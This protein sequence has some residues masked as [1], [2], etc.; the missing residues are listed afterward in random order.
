MKS[1]NHH[2][3]II[4]GFALAAVFFI[5]PL[6]QPKQCLWNKTAGNDGYV[7]LAHIG[8]PAKTAALSV[9]SFQLY[10][11]CYASVIRLPEGAGGKWPV[12]I[13]AALGQK[14]YASYQRWNTFFADCAALAC[15]FAVIAKIRKQRT[16]QG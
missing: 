2:K 10:P 7:A 9:L 3:Y 6:M 15:I 5:L 14:S 1:K 16:L 13:A 11:S 8:E 4:T 12:H